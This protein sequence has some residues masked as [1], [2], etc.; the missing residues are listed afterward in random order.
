MPCIKRSKITC[1]TEFRWIQHQSG[2]MSLVIQYRTRYIQLC[3]VVIVGCKKLPCSGSGCAKQFLP[4]GFSQYW[5]TLTPRDMPQ[6]LLVGNWK[7]Q[8]LPVSTLALS[9][10][11]QQVECEWWTSSHSLSGLCLQVHRTC[12][13][14]FI[15]TGQGQVEQIFYFLFFWYWG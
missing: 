5:R 8:S 9:I 2:I 13:V 14:T 6:Q 1:T 3:R 4:V 10:H 7:S 11:S 15:E 12:Q